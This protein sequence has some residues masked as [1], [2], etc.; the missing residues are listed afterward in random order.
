M[1]NNRTQEWNAKKQGN[2]WR[3]PDSPL[4]HVLY[5]LTKKET[6]QLLS[7]DAINGGIPAKKGKA[8]GKKKR[9]QKVYI[10]P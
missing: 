7:S 4:S 9:R 8:Y 1:G 10:Y 3:P 5:D 6:A 2:K